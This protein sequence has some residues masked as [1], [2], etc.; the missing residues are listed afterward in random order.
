MSDAPT[1]GRTSRKG[2]ALTPTDPPPSGTRGLLASGALVVSILLVIVLSPASSVSS[3]AVV[4]LAAV[5]GAAAAGQALFYPGL[6]RRLLGAYAAPF[7]LTFEL[8]LV[9]F[10]LSLTG[11]I[12]SELYPLLLLGAALA[13]RLEGRDAGRFLTLETVLGLAYL[14]SLAPPAVSQLR[15][16]LLPLALRGLWPIA[17]LLAFEIRAVRA[18]VRE[19][20]ANPRTLS[21]TFPSAVRGPQA[22]TSGSDRTEAVLHDLKSPLSVVRA[23]AD[24]IA[25]GARR[26]QAPAPEH[27]ANLGRELD[28]MEAI[29]AARPRPAGAA[30][31][32]PGAPPRTAAPSTA[33][34]RI[35]RVDLVPILSSL[36]EA[37][38]AAHGER[39]RIEFLADDAEIQV[40]ADPVA[41]QRAFRNV[42]DNSVKYSRDGGP[43][44]IRVGVRADRALVVFTDSGAGMSAEEQAR[45]FDF[46]FRGRE[47]VASGIEGKGLGLGV[48]RELLEANGGRISLRS[49]P[50]NG[51]EVTV[52]LP[53]F[54]ERRV[55]ERRERRA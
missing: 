12:R 46:A 32:G 7:A 17:L 27:V 55:R 45:A 53:A 5:A 2:E 51:L 9:L 33:A 13:Y 1:S 36:A 47:A 49:E 28:L 40:L 8:A 4:R 54:R 39:H 26:G 15:E 30:G 29:V 19:V 16:V 41:L 6:H 34:G 21:G 50:G 44:R 11:G 52:D 24:L 22:A 10:A 48:S 25:E 18:E 35:A 31:G 43:V 37:Y 38:R 23:Y 3:L 42:L 20:P 14:V